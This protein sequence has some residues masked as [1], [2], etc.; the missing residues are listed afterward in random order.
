MGADLPLPYEQGL[1]N[2]LG[3]CFMTGEAS[4]QRSGLGLSS[5]RMGFDRVPWYPDHDSAPASLSAHTYRV[6]ALAAGASLTFVLRRRSLPV[7]FGEPLGSGIALQ[8]IAL[9]FGVD[10]RRSV[11][12][13]TEPFTPPIRPQELGTGL[14]DPV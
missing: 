5:Y 11:R 9:D 3:R 14:G 12:T 10:G 6:F 13:S 2:Q 8:G 4:R 7:M 1:R